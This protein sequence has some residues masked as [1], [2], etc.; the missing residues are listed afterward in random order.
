MNA[1]VSVSRAIWVGILGVTW[2]SIAVVAGGLGAVVVYGRQADLTGW[3]ALLVFLLPFVVGWCWWYVASSRWW[4]WA[5]SRV[6]DRDKFV[7]QAAASRLGS[8]PDRLYRP[9]APAP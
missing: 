8:P 1:T 6:A 7:R 5:L 2:S 4:A 3:P 9:S